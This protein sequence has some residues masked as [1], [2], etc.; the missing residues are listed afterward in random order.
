MIAAEKNI[1]F[2]QMGNQGTQGPTTTS[3]KAWKEAG[4]I[5][6]VTKITSYM[7]SGKTLAPMEV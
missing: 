1:K 5:K 3:S 6:D 7:N 4:V 2:R